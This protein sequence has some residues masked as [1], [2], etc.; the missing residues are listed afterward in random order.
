MCTPT[1]ALDTLSPD[2]RR[3]KLQTAGRVQ[4]GMELKI[5]G[6]NGERLSHDGK[7]PGDLWVRSGWAA[8]GYFRDETAKLD[9]DGWFPTGD[10]AT[11]DDFGYMR[12]TDRTKDVIKSG[13]EWISSVDVEGIVYAHPAVRMA[14][15]VGAAHPKWEERPV[16]IVALKESQQLSE[17]ELIEFLRPRMARWW[18]PDR[19]FFVPEMPMTATGKIRKTV[20]RE[21]YR[22]ILH[23]RTAAS[24]A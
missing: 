11:I 10:V 12:I 1:P 3:K 13:G 14:A 17:K 9:A 4:Y 7:N 16:L 24:Q 2:D 8:K 5:V 6:P 21:Q 22:E 19:V 15:V 23:P 18:L 20:L